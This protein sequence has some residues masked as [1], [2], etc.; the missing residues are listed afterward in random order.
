MSY[1]YV[2]KLFDEIDEKL[3]FKMDGNSKL[4]HLLII[5]ITEKN[6]FQ[7]KLFKIF[8]DHFM[9]IID[10]NMGKIIIELFLR[11]TKLENSHNNAI[12][13]FDEII[14]CDDLYTE[15]I[16][17]NYLKHCCESSQCSKILSK[18]KSPYEILKT[19]KKSDFVNFLAK[20]DKIDIVIESLL[21]HSNLD[22]FL[23]QK[24]VKT[25]LDSINKSKFGSILQQKWKD[26]FNKYF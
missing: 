14:D 22:N 20:I 12:N 15:N 8:C 3:F 26:K 18:L 2:I 10:T 6:F 1:G 23:K 13:L 4:L 17:L 16:I 9:K 25:N 19:T 24:D 5:L 11:R 7:P 21:K